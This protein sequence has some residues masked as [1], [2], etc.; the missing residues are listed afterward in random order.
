[1]A[2]I[3]CCDFAARAKLRN[4][5]VLEAG[6]AILPRHIMLQCNIPTAARAFCT[7]AYDDVRRGFCALRSQPLFLKACVIPLI[8]IHRL[9][10]EDRLQNGAHGFNADDY[11]LP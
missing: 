6:L 11:K 2:S 9:D 5:R 4:N 7:L 8:D 10:I 1:L 3:D